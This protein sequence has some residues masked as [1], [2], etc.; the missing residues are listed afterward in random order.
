MAQEP[1]PYQKTAPKFT[2]LNDLAVETVGGKICF[3]TDDYFAVA[4]NLLKPTAP[5]FK[6][7]LFTEFGKWMDGWETRRKRGWLVTTGVSYS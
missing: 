5:V 6:E 1:K 4:D 7:G 2:E 3:S